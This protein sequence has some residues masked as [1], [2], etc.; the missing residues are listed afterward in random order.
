MTLLMMFP[1]KHTKVNSEETRF[2]RDVD[3]LESFEE[4]ISIREW[5]IWDSK[6][7][8]EKVYEDS[9]IIKK[10]KIKNGL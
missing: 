7:F 9:E 8:T 1:T 10:I 2:E 5:I 4:K 3:K 6:D